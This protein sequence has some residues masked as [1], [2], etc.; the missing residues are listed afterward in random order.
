V[1]ATGNLG[2]IA[3]SWRRASIIPT[4]IALREAMPLLQR[5]RLIATGLAVLCALPVSAAERLPIEHFTRR[6]AISDV[7]ISPS[8]THLAILVAGPKGYLQ[9]GV[10]QLNPIGD[11][12]VLAGFDDA[13]VDD[14]YWINDDRLTY[15]AF[16]REGEVRDAGAAVFA[17][18]R[19]GSDQRALI[20]WSRA[21][22]RP[23]HS[24]ES[25]VLPYGWFLHS[26]IDDGSDDVFV[27][28]RDTDNAGELRGTELAR[29]NTRT[30]ALRNLSRGAPDGVRRWLLDA[31][32][33]PRLLTSYVDGRVHI[34]WRDGSLPGAGWTEVAAFDPLGAFSFKPLRI[35]GDRVLVTASNGRDTEALYAFDPRTRQIEPEPL[36]AV[37]G[38]DLSP[39]FETDSRT[40]R[41]V[42]LHAVADRRFSVWFDADLHRLQRSIDAALPAGRVNRLYC[43]RCETSRFVVIWSSS[44]RQPGE[45]FLFDRTSRSLERIG[46]ARPWIDE[47]TQGRRSFHRV[48]TPDGLAMPLI[49]THPVGVAD[50]PTPAVVVVHGGP[51]VRG[52]DLGWDATAQFLASRGYRVLQPEFRGSTGFGMRL[53]QAGWKQWGRAMQDDLVTAVQWAAKEGLVDASRVCIYG[54]SYGGY[55][56]L[57]GPIRHP[58]MYRCAASFAGVTDIDLM[59]SINWSDTSEVARRYSMP[60]LIGDPAKDSER[61]AEVS[62]LRRV[63]RIKVPLLLAHGRVD[64]RVPV[65]HSERFEGAARSAGVEIDAMYFSAEGHG[66]SD[67]RNK[68]A[69]LGRLDELLARALAPSR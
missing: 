68:S 16:P 18:D 59:Y 33:E 12:R 15:S 64:R 8:G 53:F 44:D 11:V 40:G 62:P 41:V 47:V 46:A 35:D 61:L 23:I 28:R 4:S 10:M 54:A 50:G 43:G 22:G 27:V 55:A 29:L 5:I 51:W 69:F 26:T 25:K 57:M 63:G 66:F 19:D 38:F 21:P 24:M 31:K 67:P 60:V 14:V 49:V 6:P 1:E 20:V 7:V 32:H 9:L 42:G 39:I 56:A 13:D 52:S 37:T 65:E 2:S 30:G 58:T 36:L 48:Q 34:Y 17:I 45:F 3:I